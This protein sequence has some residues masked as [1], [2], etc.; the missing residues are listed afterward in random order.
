M[1]EFTTTK[2]DF[3]NF[4]LVMAC[5]L[6][7]IGL[8]I[9]YRQD[10]QPQTVPFVLWGLALAFL[11]FGLALPTVLKPLYLPWMI[12]AALLNWVVTRLILGLFFFLVLVPMGTVMRL[13][14][15][16]PMDRR[17]PRHKIGTCWKP[18]QDDG[19]GSRHFENPF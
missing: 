18:R 2:K 9:C 6:A 11:F 16:D 15:Y 14:G 8:Y 7:L 19:R 13:F 4:G 1:F 5:A 3:R 12:L 10:W 17:W